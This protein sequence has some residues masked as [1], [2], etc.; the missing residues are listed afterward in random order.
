MHKDV[1]FD[2][3]EGAQPIGSNSLCLN[4]G[5]YYPGRYVT[6]QGHPEF[7]NEIISEI[8]FNRHRDGIISDELY[9]SGVERSPIPH[10]GVAVGRSFLKFLQ[11]G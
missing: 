10:D 11:Q 5:M 9:N 3:P 4:Q 2:Y 6:V 1:V 7:N 8:L